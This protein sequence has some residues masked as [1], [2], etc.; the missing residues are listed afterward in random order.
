MEKKAVKCVIKLS[1]LYTL[2]KDKTTIFS[3]QVDVYIC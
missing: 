2:L 3:N 1:L